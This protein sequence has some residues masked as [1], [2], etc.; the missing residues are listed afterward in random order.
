MSKYRQY[1]CPALLGLEMG[2]AYQPRRASKIHTKIRVARG[3]EEMGVIRVMQYVQGTYRG[4]VD[5]RM[6]TVAGDI[7]RGSISDGCPDVRDTVGRKAQ[8]NFCL[9]RC[10]VSVR[11]G[12]VLWG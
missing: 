2:D 1:A 6:R 9:D 3:W 5:D 11:F 4:A 12:L 10:W 8:C 7:G